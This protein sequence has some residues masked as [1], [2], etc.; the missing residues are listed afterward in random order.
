MGTYITCAFTG[1][2]SHKEEGSG[3][4]DRTDSDAG[5][6]TEKRRRVLHLLIAAAGPGLFQIVIQSVFGDLERLTEEDAGL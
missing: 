5:S 2:L 3:T 1:R 4:E 6:W